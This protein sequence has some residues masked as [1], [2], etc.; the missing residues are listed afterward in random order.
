MNT[1]MTAKEYLM[2]ILK[3]EQPKLPADMPPLVLKEERMEPEDSFHTGIISQCDIDNQRAYKV[4]FDKIIFRNVTFSRISMKEI[5]LTDVI[6]EK[7]D[8]SNVDFGTATI[9]RTEF[10]DCK[11]MGMNLSD[12]TIRNTGFYNCLGDYLTL[13]M[14]NLKQVLFHQC[15]LIGAD[16]YEAT[17][18]KIALEDC[19]LDQAQ[20]SGVKLEGIDLSTNSFA[21][22][23]VNVENLRGCIISREQAAVFANLIGLQLK[24]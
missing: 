15:S 13:R 5:E 14:A 7:C 23:G 12:A 16:F 11:I 6:F 24:D 1:F 3:I 2:S 17:V 22:L 19:K 20:L 4:A 18:Q 21:R 10:R 8:L 9:H